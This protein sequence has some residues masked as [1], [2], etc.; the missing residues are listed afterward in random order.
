KEPQASVDPETGIVTS[1]D[2]EVLFVPT[3]EVQ[4]PEELD[5]RVS[6][7]LRGYAT[8]EETGISQVLN[9]VDHIQ[10]VQGY[11]DGTVQP[12]GNVT[13]AEVCMMFYRLLLKPD[14]AKTQEF[15]DI[16]DGKWYAEA[17]ETLAG[18][19]ILNGYPDGTFGPDRAITREEF[20]AIAMRFAKNTE[21]NSRFNDVSEDD[22]ARALIGAAADYGWIN[23]YE[24]NS[25]R[26]KNSIRRSET[27]AIINHMLY[28]AAD[29]A[30]TES[31]EEVV[32]RFTDLKDRSA[33]Y[34]GEV[35]EATGS[36]DYEL[37][38]YFES[39]DSSETRYDLEG[40]RP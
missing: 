33:W 9:T 22:W 39:W 28:R 14:V 13:R 26:P 40:N 1:A 35:I 3:G 16:Q 4:K 34:F 10:Y 27:M 17:V 36:H 38:D 21:G 23:G 19:G 6:M 12:D 29:E 18:M 11:T 25:F 20:T 8:P 15:S 2:G 32:N 30:Y 5:N 37:V 24:D 31:N 7:V